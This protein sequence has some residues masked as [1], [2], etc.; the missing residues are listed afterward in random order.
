MNLVHGSL[1]SGLDAPSVAASWLGWKNAFHCEINPFCNVILNYWFPE[2]EH[3]EDIT[4]TDFRKWRGRIDVLTGGFPCQPF[5]VAGQRKGADDDRYL[6]PEFKRAIREI[7]PTWV[8]GENVGGI[9]TMVQPGDEVEVGSQASLFG[10][11]NRKR[12]LL[13]QQYVVETI[14]SDLERE[15]YSVWP[16]VIPACA[17]GAPHRRDR[18]WFVAHRNS[19]G[20]QEERP[21]QQATRTSGI[22]TQSAT[23]RSDTGVEDVQRARE[24]GILSGVY[25]T[26]TESNG[27]GRTSGEA[28]R[29]FERQ[30]RN[31]TEQSFVR[32]EIRT[33]A[34]A[35]SQRHS[36]CRTSEKIERIGSKYY[37]EQKERE[38]SPEW[39]DGLH[40]FPQSAAHTNGERCYDGCD[41]R[42]ERHV[43]N[44]QKRD[45]E[46]DKPER[47]ERKCG[48]GENGAAVTDTDSKMLQER[49]KTG[50][51]K[52]KEKDRTR[53]DDGIERF[54]ELR[55]AADT[56]IK[57]L[58][59][60]CNSRK[61]R[62]ERT[63]P[64]NEQ[65]LGSFCSIWR[66][67]PT[68]P[69]VCRGNDGLPFDVDRLTIPFSRWRQE[70]VK[71]F[72]NAIVPQ[73]ILEIFK[74]IEA[75][76]E[77]FNERK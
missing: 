67:F 46:E 39:V 4:K 19:A 8:V 66:N 24:D 75:A 16:L 48:A 26:D 17:V 57:R 52:N 59:R 45:S 71:G 42:G 51:R 63:K 5:S 47:D 73:V 77:H 41:N 35:D 61:H 69:P 28:G 14:C 44:D 15:G 55:Y 30:N 3:Y 9:I 29:A 58:Q 56:K 62:K 10:E 60:G 49:F 21:E 38:Q 11:D 18:V 43:Y 54:G 37:G 64:F 25:A 6:W 40:G 53:V 74:A 72:G 32:S 22:C 65:S 31:E 36:S 12:V 34:H 7:Q 50:G 33:A 27:S 76:E 68:Q 13:R 23:H 1:F 2:S 70:S 20:I